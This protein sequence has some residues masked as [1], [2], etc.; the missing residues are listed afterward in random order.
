M[1]LACKGLLSDKKLTAGR[2]VSGVYLELL[3]CYMDG[4]VIEIGNK[5]D[6]DYAAGYT[7]TRATITGEK[8]TAVSR[9]YSRAV[10]SVLSGET[11]AA[12]AATA[13]Q[14]EVVTITGFPT[15]RP[16]EMIH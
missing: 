5:S 13:L 9:A 1:C 7:G 16:E 12:D 8:Y 15:A 6:Y 10:Y 4:G 2:D 3:A 11:S 14:K